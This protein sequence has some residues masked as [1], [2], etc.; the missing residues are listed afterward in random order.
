VTSVGAGGTG[1]GGAGSA[2]TPSGMAGAAGDVSA[3]GGS[4][5][6][7]GS[8]GAA[9]AF[10]E[11]ISQLI[12]GQIEPHGLIVDG[13]YLWWIASKV[14]EGDRVRRMR[15]DGSQFEI[16][17]DTERAQCF[18]LDEQ[19]VY[20]GERYDTSLVPARVRAEPRA[21]GPVADFGTFQ[22][23]CSR[24]AVDETSLYWTLGAE[25]QV[26]R[27]DKG[28]GEPA[29]IAVDQTGVSDIGVDDTY[30]FWTRE[31]SVDSTMMRWTKA[32]PS[33]PPVAVSP[34]L[35]GRSRWLLL[36]DAYVYAAHYTSVKPADAMARLVRVSK[37]GGEA[38]VLFDVPKPQDPYWLAKDS[39]YLYS[40]YGDPPW[41]GSGEAVFVRGVPLQ[42]Q[43]LWTAKIFAGGNATT[44]LAV[45]DDFLYWTR[46]CDVV[47][48]TLCKS[49][50]LAGVWRMPK[51]K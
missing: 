32:D 44:S 16:L 26:W 49:D 19:N 4:A 8:V 2:G 27:V 31:N 6:D 1:Q 14:G 23:G 28:G 12:D 41:S 13:E 37:E 30:V 39:G 48:P 25:G 34:G 40:T 36:D 18:A 9:G 10:A 17:A 38:V 11:G 42:G 21:G 46:I 47:Q 35:T 22:A 15:K 24:M 43:D 33:A 5:G 29:L 3:I 20:W 7:A 51:P 45:D 50:P